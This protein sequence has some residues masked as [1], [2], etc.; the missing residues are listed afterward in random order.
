MNRRTLVTVVLIAGLWAACGGP[1]CRP[2]NEASTDA[3][4][5]TATSRAGSGT[6]VSLSDAHFDP[7][8]DP[9]LFAELMT[10]EA[11]GW[12]LV[13]E[14][15]EL[16]DIA[17]AGSDSNYNLLA[18]ALRAAHDAAPEPDFVIYSGDF[19]AHGFQEKFEDAIGKLPSAGEPTPGD[20]RSG[21]R[22]PVQCFIDRTVEFVS[23]MLRE[24]FAEAPIYP[25]LGNNDSYCGDYKIDPVG[26]FVEQAEATWSRLLIDPANRASFNS[27]FG[28]G[29]HYTV[30]P[31]ASGGRIVT[32]NT[33]LFSRNY[34]NACETSPH[35]PTAQLE[36]L[37]A[38]LEEAERAGE[39]VMILSHI[40][41]GTD[42]YATLHRGSVDSVDKVVEFW[43]PEYPPA[44]LDV[45]A[46]HGAT[47]R[48]ILA[49]H[50]H[51]DMFTLVPRAASGTV[52]FEHITPGIS[53]LFGNN[54]AFEVVTYDR[55]EFAV[56]DY[57]AYNLPAAGAAA[58]EPPSWQMEYRFT[59]AYSVAEVS[60]VTLT[61]LWQRLQAAGPERERFERYF[62]AGNEASTSFTDENRPAYW[63]GLG[64]VTATEFVACVA[65]R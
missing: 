61:D 18:S 1:G 2:A 22:P 49:G 38:Q 19:L 58:G 7:F 16:T 57:T 33:I 55:N 32:L 6:F 50:T 46:S 21:D 35:S 14:S 26:P 60:V 8:H 62:A 29:G 65:G 25:V 56:L 10:T 34:E 51:M 42:V 45:I 20:C 63:C 44:F 24:S 9:D 5:A 4:T 28:D 31:P 36:W 47:L 13:F 43:K 48:G 39:G 27:T 53:P 64:T 3:P 37:S 12:S 30:T 54:P 40:P 17:P 59:E 41:V 15:S 11:S 52:T 23:L